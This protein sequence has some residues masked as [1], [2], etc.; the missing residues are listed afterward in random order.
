[1]TLLTREDSK[2]AE[3]AA[4]WL[5]RMLFEPSMDCREGLVA[6][7]QLSPRNIEEFLLAQ[8]TY[9]AFHRIDPQREIDVHELV[10]SAQASI[11][12]LRQIGMDADRPEAS[13]ETPASEIHA[14]VIEDLIRPRLQ[15]KSGFPR[16]ARVVGAVVVIVGAVMGWQYYANPDNRTYSTGLGEQHTIRLS[17]GSLIELNT[18]SKA[19]VHFSKALRQVRLL[20]GEA[21]FVVA[22]DTA[23]PFR[24]STDTATIQA[25]GTQFDVYRGEAST[26]VAVVEGRIQVASDGSGSSLPISVGGTWTKSSEQPTQ[27]QAVPTLLAAGEQAQVTPGHVEKD[28]R[29]NVTNAVA[30]RQRRLVFDHTSLADVVKELARY[31]D[32]RI[33]LIGGE[34]LNRR[35]SGVFQADDP[36]TIVA[37]LESDNTVKVQHV[38][39]GVII[40]LR[41]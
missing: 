9:R 8:T 6:W 38:E 33:G 2:L 29:P 18:R 28:V 26:R 41:N 3:E 10:A 27:P 19:E 30:W 4:E 20:E 22:H 7:L 23:R 25:V 21:L 34:L 39:N 31:S 11:V 37:L 32:F 40:T 17:D 14:A 24:V 35:I 13:V 15:R 1:M 16:W 36:Q 12:P 5:T